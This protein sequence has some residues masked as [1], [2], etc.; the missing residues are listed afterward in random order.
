M[1]LTNCKQGFSVYELDNTDYKY[2][3][4]VET[5]VHDLILVGNNKIQRTMGNATYIVDENKIR[6]VGRTVFAPTK[7][8]YYFIDADE[9]G[10]VMY[11][12]DYPVCY[13]ETLTRNRRI[14][15]E[16]LPNCDGWFSC[17]TGRGVIALQLGLPEFNNMELI[18]FKPATEKM[19]IS[20]CNVIAWSASLDV[21]EK[22]YYDKT[23]DGIILSFSGEGKVLI[24]NQ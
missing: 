11:V 23:F 18:T 15:N 24:H 3:L 19:D 17:Y 16:Q 20:I 5:S 8:P 6:G 12:K 13:T 9:W 2:Q 1:K 7:S 10:N 4:H 21:K 14:S 22:F